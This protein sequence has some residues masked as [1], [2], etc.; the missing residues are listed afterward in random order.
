MDRI[1]ECNGLEKSDATNFRDND[2]RFR[3]VAGS[4]KRLKQVF[5]LEFRYRRENK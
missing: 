3:F 1:Y 5:V 2:T 4:S